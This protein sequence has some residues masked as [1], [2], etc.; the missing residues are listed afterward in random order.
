M[1]VALPDW[2][3]PDAVDAIAMDLDRT[4]LPASL[5][6]TPATLRAVAAARAAGIEPIVATGRMFRSA[7]PYA[8]Q[9]GVVAPLICYQGALVADPVGGDWLEHRP[10]P[11]PLARTAIEAVA[12]AGFHMN[13]Y[14]DDELYVERINDEALE[15]A[16]HSRLQPHAVGD[17]RHWLSEPTTKIVVVGEPRG[18]DGLEVQ[19]RDRFDGELF[20]AKSLPHFLELAVPGVSKGS[21]LRWVCERLGIDPA[22]VVAFGDGEN[23]VELLAE[24]GTAIA[25]EDADPKL[26]RH[27]DLTVPG[28][29]EDGVATFVQ[30]LVDSRGRCS[31]PS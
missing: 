22:R 16:R 18:L 9:L 19:L 25:V 4:I 27:A 29:E 3:D 13:V 14:V 8:R 24:A 1:T 7:R 20:I 5:E 12:A 17:L 30:A 2:L 28:V 15:Y 26:L 21:A 6:L 31:T 10:M 11:V 23:D